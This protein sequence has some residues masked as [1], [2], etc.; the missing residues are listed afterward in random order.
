LNAPADVKEAEDEARDAD[1][2]APPIFAPVL[3]PKSRPHSLGL[4]FVV[5]SRDRE[6][7]L[8]LSVT[9]ARYQ[10][11]SKSIWHRQPRI[12]LLHVTAAQVLWIDSN[13]RCVESPGNAE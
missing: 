13:G 1:I 3:D 5:K 10:E 2:D 9:W 6:P 11:Q 8:D 7:V 12:S 4:S